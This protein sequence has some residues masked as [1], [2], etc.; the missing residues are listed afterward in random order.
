MDEAVNPILLDSSI[1]GD[2]NEGSMDRGEVK[3]DK[4]KDKAKEHRQRIGTEQE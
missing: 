4:R 2:A 3:K 1:Q